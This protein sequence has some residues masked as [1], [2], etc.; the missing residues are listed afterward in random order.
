MQLHYCSIHAKLLWYLYNYAGIFANV[1]H[2][3]ESVQPHSV[4]I[5]GGGVI[6]VLKYDVS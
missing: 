1:Y 2:F 6:R 4:V 3:Y 5:E